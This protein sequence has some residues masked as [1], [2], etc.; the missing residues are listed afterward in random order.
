MV[1]KT[2]RYEDLLVW[3]KSVELSVQVFNLTREFPKEELFGLAQQ[4]RRCA[5][6]VP[7]NIAEGSER[8]SDK[9]F[10]RFLNISLGS[11][12]ELKTQIIIADKVNLISNKISS[13]LK[14]NI[15]EIAKMLKSLKNKLC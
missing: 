3:Q 13:E 10:S 5:V 4:M 8:G 7:S 14:N 15:D 1:N 9:E 2:K 6:S 11:L 12:A